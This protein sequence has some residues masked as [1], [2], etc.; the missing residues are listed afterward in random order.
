MDLCPVEPAESIPRM[1]GN[2]KKGL[3]VAG[4]VCIVA[5]VALAVVLAFYWSW[6]PDRS[7]AVGDIDRHFIE[8]MVPHHEDAVLMAE[9]ALTKSEH[10]ELRQLAENIKRD[11]SR[12]IDQMRSWYR[13]WYGVDLHVYDYDG[14]GP[15]EGMM[16]GGMMGMGM[17]GRGMIDDG[18]DLEVLETASPFDREFIRQMVPHH[19]MGIMMA[20]MVLRGSE[21]PEIQELARSIIDTQSAEI[22]QMLEWYR[23]WYED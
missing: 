22:E 18:T 6:G 17:M 2:M 15:G 4:A 16:D 1:R 21:R 10:P 12:E 3:V 20:Q 9:L 8:Q 7:Q 19:Q 23:D 11:Q 13:S 14:D 5:G